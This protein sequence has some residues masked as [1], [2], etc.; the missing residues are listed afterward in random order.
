MVVGVLPFLLTLL[1]ICVVAL[2][3]ILV[4][5]WPHVHALRQGG[6]APS[7]PGEALVPDWRPEP[8]RSP[9]APSAYAS[10]ADPPSPYV[11]A[12]APV[13]QPAPVRPT[14]PVR[15]PA[16]VAQ[17]AAVGRPA[18][19][20]PAPVRPPAPVGPPASVGPPAPVGRTAPPDRPAVPVPVP[21]RVPGA[22]RPSAAPVREPVDAEPVLRHVV[23]DGDGRTSDADPP[24]GGAADDPLGFALQPFRSRPGRRPGADRP[25]G[26]R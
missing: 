5:A 11:Q 26:S 20:P 4:F 25:V 19:A 17:P 22:D 24:A 14:A 23:V 2:A 6:G 13:A 7:R 16:P 10:P 1:M 18:A 12:P 3:V 8:A 21:D 15:P 9:Y